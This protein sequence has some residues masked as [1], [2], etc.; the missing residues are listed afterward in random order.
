MEPGSLRWEKLLS[1]T[2][3]KTSMWALAIDSDTRLD[4]WVSTEN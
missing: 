2:G 3:E 1:E 4:T